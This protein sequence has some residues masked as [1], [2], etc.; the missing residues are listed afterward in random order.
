MFSSSIRFSRPKQSSTGRRQALP[1][2][3]SKDRADHILHATTSLR[4]GHL[5]Q[6]CLAFVLL[7]AASCATT[8]TEVHKRPED[9]RSGDFRI[10]GRVEQAKTLPA[11]TLTLFLLGDGKTVIPTV[12]T[13]ARRSGD[14]V[15]LKTKLLGLGT[16]RTPLDAEDKKVLKDTLRKSRVVGEPLLDLTVEAI[17]VALLAVR[18]VAGRVYFLLEVEP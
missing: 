8:P 18:E 6:I 13:K 12:S 17:G 9:F 2:R 15:T 11:T 5:S 4:F 3:K 7:I 16:G 14:E 1:A 10:R